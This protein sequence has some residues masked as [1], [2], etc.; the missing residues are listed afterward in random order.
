MD[1]SQNSQCQENRDRIYSR[2]G[3]RYRL[4]ELGVRYEGADA[5]VVLDVCFHIKNYRFYD[6]IGSFDNVALIMG[7]GYD[8]YDVYC[9]H[10]AQEIVS[11]STGAERAYPAIA[12]GTTLPPSGEILV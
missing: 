3:L 10:R 4:R 7:F 12:A 1:L 2:L 5:D 9:P 8:V 6:V 11:K